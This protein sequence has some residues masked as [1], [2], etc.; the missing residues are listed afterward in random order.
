[1]HGHPYKR[2]TPAQEVRRAVQS[3]FDEWTRTP[4]N[5]DLQIGYREEWLWEQLPTVNNGFCHTRITLSGNTR[6]SG[7]QAR[8]EGPYGVWL[9]DLAGPSGPPRTD[10]QAYRPCTR[11]WGQAHCQRE[12]NVWHETEEQRRERARAL[13]KTDPDAIKS[14][15]PIIW[16]QIR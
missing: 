5:N 10:E 2:G 12:S 15:R 7:G 8:Y 6:F 3:I 13:L 11:T 4:G 9:L 14:A 1:M 16:K